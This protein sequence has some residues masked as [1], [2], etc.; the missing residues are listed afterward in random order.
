MTEK[1]KVGFGKLDIAGWKS[2]GKSFLITVAGAVIGFI[3]DLTGVADFGSYQTI[4][5]T[6]LPF[7]ANFLYKLLGTY[8]SK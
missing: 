1:T 2:I 4:L 3:A 7:V 5:A 6:T 8:T